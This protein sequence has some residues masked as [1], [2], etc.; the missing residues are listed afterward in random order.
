MITIAPAITTTRK[1]NASA[2]LRSG[3]S[4][5]LSLEDVDR[6]VHDDP[7]HV[8]EMPVDPAELDAVMM[9]GGEVPPEGADRHEQE[10]READEDVG[11]VQ[12]REAEEDRGERAVTRV[13]ADAGVLDSL[14]D[15][16]RQ[17]HEEREQQPG[18]KAQPVAALDRGRRP[19][20][21]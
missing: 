18:A 6:Q 21:R 16:E 19:V 3:F 17:A 14:G 5:V 4:T 13:E 15:E 1:R 11:A 2:S 8:D 20:D 7:H 10:D 9:L 12:A